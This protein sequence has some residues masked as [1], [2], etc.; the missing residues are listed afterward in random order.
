M[1]VKRTEN[2]RREPLVDWVVFLFWVIALVTTCILYPQLPEQVP[3]HWGPSGE[4]DVWVPALTAV[5]VGLGLPVV[6]YLATWF[7]PGL[8]GGQS[9]YAGPATPYRLTRRGLVSSFIILHLV[10][11]AVGLGVE[12]WRAFPFG[13]GLALIVFGNIYGLIPQN[14][15]LGTRTHTTLEDSSVWKRTHRLTGLLMVV[16]G[17][18]L[19]LA[20]PFGGRWLL[21]LVPAVVLGLGLA[22][23]VIAT[24]AGRV[25]RGSDRGP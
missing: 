9:G 23:F 1:I 3:F 10:V 20:A 16:S 21:G 22:S 7:A 18:V 8:I 12:L 13:V 2:T 4:A 25:S 17:L 6:I 15:F 5:I 24:N 19:L 14:R 11:L